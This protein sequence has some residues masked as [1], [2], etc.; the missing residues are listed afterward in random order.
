M[1][2]AGGVYSVPSLST[3]FKMSKSA[4]MFAIAS[5]ILASARACPG[6]TLAH[7]A[8]TSKGRC[9][10]STWRWAHGHCITHLRPNPNTKLLG[11]M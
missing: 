5:Q 8:F 11:A 10:K 3:G 1:N 7:A 4:T 2:F 6:Q 9:S